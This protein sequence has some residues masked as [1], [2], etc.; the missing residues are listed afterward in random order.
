MGMVWRLMVIHCIVYLVCT[1]LR[2]STYLAHLATVNDNILE[3][4]WKGI[5]PILPPVAKGCAGLLGPVDIPLQ[6]RI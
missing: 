5:C 2:A 6:N 3:N 1:N 4:L